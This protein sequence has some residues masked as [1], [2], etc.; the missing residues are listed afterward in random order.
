MARFLV[1]D[2]DR[3]TVSGLTRLLSDDGHEV[4]PF[5]AGAE[6]IDALVHQPFD[7]VVTDLEMPRVDG[8]EVTRVTRQH[9]P[10]A[11]LVVATAKAEEVAEILEAAGACFVADKPLDYEEL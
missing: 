5:T 2:D 1:V 3:A 7:A 10:E 11:C 6:A 8:H 4:T 9:Q